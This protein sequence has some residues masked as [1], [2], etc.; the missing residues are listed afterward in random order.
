[1]RKMSG[2]LTLFDIVTEDIKKEDVQHESATINAG[3]HL[4]RVER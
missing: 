1:M 4:Y 2:Q 3:Q